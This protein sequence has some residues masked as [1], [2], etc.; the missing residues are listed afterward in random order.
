MATSP[1]KPSRPAE[2]R[3]DHARPRNAPAPSDTAIEAR[4]E[5]LI[6]PATY[7]VTAQYHRLG[8]R[9]RILT[10]PVMVSLVV[11]LIWRQVPSV[12]MLARLLSREQLLWTPPRRV[13]QQ[14]L[15][16][17]LRCLPAALFGEVVQAILPEL[18]R[19]ARERAR[20]LPPVLVRAQQHF[21]HL[22]SVDATTLEALFKKVGLLED[23]PQTVLGGKLLGALDLVT[24]L[25]VHLIWDANAAVNERS[26][27]DRL[28]PLLP[29]G[30]LLVLDKGF[31]GFTLFDRLTAAGH[32]FIL[33]DRETTVYTVVQR[34]ASNGGMVDEI[35]RLGVYRSSPCQSLV[36]RIVLPVGGVHYGY[37]T[38][39]LDPSVLTV[40]D[41]AELYRERWRIEEAFSLVK[42]LLGLS[43]LWTGAENGIALQI[44]ATWLLYAVLVDLSDA[45]AEARHLPFA[46][47]S[48]EM[49]FR[50]LYFFV[51]AHARGETHDPVHY[52]AT[53]DDL[54]IVKRPKPPSTLDLALR[55]LT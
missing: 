10:L 9:A 33:P 35:I 42:R 37:L 51:G 25:P 46:R 39:V 6:S 5:E 17:R 26:L 23:I 1:R 28:E 34:L 36:R 12:H 29:S 13:S 50:S 11:T 24:R 47:I 55:T 43:Y 18:A 45:V 53:Q 20:P 44:W 19:R 4:L 41:V 27:L 3:R 16:Q 14:A 54:G 52:L 32:A 38:N 8:L 49:V 2:L 15:N 22:W 30:L 40:R 21:R 31:F 48:L 7:A